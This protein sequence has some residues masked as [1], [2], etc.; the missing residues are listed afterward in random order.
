MMQKREGAFGEGLRW[1]RR[2]WR[3]ERGFVHVRR[4]IAV[5]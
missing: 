1:R 4:N 3:F 5:L 2:C